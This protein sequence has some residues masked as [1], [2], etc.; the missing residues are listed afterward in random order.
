MWNSIKFSHSNS[1]V[2]I[3]TE[4]NGV[5]T[6]NEVEDATHYNYIINDGEVLTT[7]QTTIKLEDGES[8]SVQA[9]NE[10]DISI[11]SKAIT[12]FDT[13]EKFVEGDETIYVKFHNT[14][15]DSIVLTGKGK[16]NAPAAPV[17]EY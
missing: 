15:L 12:Y 5:V 17:K 10:Y 4:E 14:D 13:S 1:A 7:T 3:T 9:A 2:Y 11:W 8:L 16:I 6:W